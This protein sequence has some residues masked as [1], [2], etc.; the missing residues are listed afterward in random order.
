MLISA[1]RLER[2]SACLDLPELVDG[3]VQVHP[4]ARHFQAGLI[5]EPAVTATVAARAGGVDQQRRQ[6]LDPAVDADMADLDSPLRQQ[7]LDVAV[8]QPVTQLAPDGEDDDV[9]R[10]T[11][12]GE[13]GP[14][15]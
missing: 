9:G 13:D 14:V 8:R 11:V 12:T 15:R 7:L 5:N 2:D 1:G 6:G 10:E 4:P 3:A